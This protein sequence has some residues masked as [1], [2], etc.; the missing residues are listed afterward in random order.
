[1]EELVS[2]SRANKCTDA[3]REREH[4]RMSLVAPPPQTLVSGAP[5]GHPS[6]AMP[7]ALPLQV[8]ALPTHGY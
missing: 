7:K 5:W 3:G 1:M 2:E 8:T 4:N 6:N